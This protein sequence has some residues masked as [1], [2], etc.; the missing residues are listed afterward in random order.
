MLNLAKVFVGLAALAFVLAIITVL[1]GGLPIMGIGGEALSRAS[2]N[3]ALL[4]IAVVLIFKSG[5]S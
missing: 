4:S 2:N 1:V 3:L 5:N